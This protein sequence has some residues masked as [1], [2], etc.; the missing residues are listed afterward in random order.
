MTKLGLTTR[1]A[2]ASDVRIGYR[3]SSV[4]MVYP[5]LNLRNNPLRFRLRPPSFGLLPK[6][7]NLVQTWNETQLTGFFGWATFGFS[8]GRRSGG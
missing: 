3:R 7:F 4:Q 6:L 1:Y 2:Y 8:Y 5:F